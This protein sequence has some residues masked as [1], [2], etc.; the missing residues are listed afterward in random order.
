MMCDNTWSIAN[1][2]SSSE[3]WCPRFLLGVSHIGML[4]LCDW[5]QLL[6]PHPPEQKQTFTV[7]HIVRINLP[8]TTGT[9]WPKAWSMQ[10]LLLGKIFQ[11]L[12]GYLL[13]SLPRA[14]P[15]DGFSLECAEFEQPRPAELA[16]SYATPSKRTEVCKERFPMISYLQCIIS[17]KQN[18]GLIMV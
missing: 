6:R 7:N 18:D 15:G 5:P 10:K 9:A 13:G 3:P 11:G 1:Q 14:S 16:L 17:S 12:R 2:G 8:G 4:S